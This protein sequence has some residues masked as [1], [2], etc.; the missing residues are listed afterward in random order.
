MTRL[1]KQCIPP[2]IIESGAHETRIYPTLVIR[3]TDLHKWYTQ[4]KYLPLS[5]K[6]AVDWTKQ[7]LPLFEDA[8][9]KV[10]R[11][12]LHPSDGLVSGDELVDGPFHPSFKDLVISSI[13]T[14][15]LSPLLRNETDKN[16]EIH[17][18]TKEIN[19]AIGHKSAN[20]KMMLEK[21][22][23]VRFVP[24]TTYPARS[25]SLKSVN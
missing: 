1:R 9:V 13:W 25:F 7:I 5:L 2:K 23:S 12:G 6:Q 3:D 4:K 14:D 16:I 10:I 22:N 15:L 17:V 8:G 24:E 11:I 21:F 18:P 20:K 19:Y